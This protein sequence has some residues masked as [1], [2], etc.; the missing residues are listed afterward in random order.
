VATAHLGEFL[1][2]LAALVWAVSVVLFRLS[3]R[4]LT[5]LALNFF[6]NIVASLLLLLT[7][8]LLR[9]D[10]LRP[11][12]FLDYARLALSGIVGIA[13][14]DT[15]FFR[16]LNIVGAGLSQVVSL[17]YSPFVIM[18]TF[19]F[20]GERLSPG[21]F[22]GA[23]LILVGIVITSGAKPPPGVTARELRAGIGLATLSV[24]L[25]ALAVAAAKPALDRSPVLWATTVRLL[26]GVVM[27]VVIT[28]VSPARRYVWGTLRPS[29]SWRVTIPA[30]VL[31]AYVAMI[32]WMAGMKFTQAST[33]SILNQTS[34]VFVLPIAGL[35]LREPITGRKLGAVLMAM[36][37][38][39]LVTLT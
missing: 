30:A 5:P 12:P 15:L 34:A 9:Q 27:L 36:A 39:G 6:K 4:K 29:R 32:V 37:G 23:G 10:L 18:F 38:V 22:L 33:A 19:I 1:S 20:L 8:A 13:V 14:A 11:A 17:S 26:A 24:A 35:V 16:S 25:M 31:G 21:D 2:V 28:I 7:H 3:G